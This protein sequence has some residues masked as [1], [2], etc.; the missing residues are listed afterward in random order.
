MSV[1]SYNTWLRLFKEP[2]VRWEQI[3]YFKSI[4]LTEYKAYV[5]PDVM[6][7]IL[8]KLGYANLAYLLIP[9]SQVIWYIPDRYV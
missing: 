6:V 1:C 9:S 8:P 5:S 3:E 2:E 4:P 7:R